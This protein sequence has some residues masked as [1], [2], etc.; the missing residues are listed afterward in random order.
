M[1]K[2]LRINK[3]IR[4]REVRVIDSDGAQLGVLDIFEARKLAQSKD[5]DLVEVAPN[6]QPPVCKVMDYGKYRYQQAK[7]HSTKHKTITVKEVK[8]RPQ[9]NE[10]DLQFKMRNARK[11]LEHGNKV[12]VTMFFRGREIVHKDLGQK[13]IDRIIAELGETATVEQTAK[14]EGNRMITVLAPKT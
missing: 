8:V 2:G 3:W 11:F 4:S 1:S 5:L 10:H 13:V 9:I 14:M 6:A 7:K 12:K